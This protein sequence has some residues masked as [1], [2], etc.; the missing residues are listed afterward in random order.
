MTRFSFHDHDVSIVGILNVTPDSFSDGG[1]FVDVDTAVAHAQRMVV[2]GAH[3]IDIGGESTRPGAPE[4]AP[5]EELERVLPVVDAL[6]ADGFA[7]S[8]DTRRPSVAEACLSHGACVVN[9]VGGLRDRDMI[10]VIAAANASVVI[11]HTPLADLAASHRYSGY[12]DVAHDVAEFLDHQAG[13]AHDAGIEEIIL[14]PG[15]GFGKS[16]DDNLVLIRHLDRLT[17]LGYPVLI[18][19]SRKRFVGAIADVADAD[20]RDAATIAV[21]LRAVTRG[22]QALR[23]HDVAGHVQALRAWVALEP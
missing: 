13:V 3:L 4:V 10:A 2:D 23:V 20:R 1:R 22:A 6:A 9:D 15:L 18:G 5:D 8:I 21:H 11:M 7:V 14:D 16:V 17:S 12:D 19:A